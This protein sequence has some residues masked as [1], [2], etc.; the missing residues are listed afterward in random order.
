MPTAPSAGWG[1]EIRSAGGVSCRSGSNGARADFGITS[2][3]T[4]DQGQNNAIY[5]RI[6]IPIGGP[7]R[8]ECNDLYNLELE[9]L[10][11]ELQ[12]LRESQESMKSITIE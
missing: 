7:K 8:V 5:A 9:R 3:P 4:T 1:D 10:R 12:M 6:I 11:L 2:E